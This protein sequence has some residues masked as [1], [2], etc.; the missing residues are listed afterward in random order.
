[1]SAAAV[2]HA[3]QQWEAAHRRL[4]EEASDPARRERLYSGV[5]RINAEL[6]RR[7]GATFTLAELAEVYG[8]SEAWVWE[9]LA[10][11]PQ[12]P[13]WPRDL[14]LI[15]DAAFHLYARGAADYRP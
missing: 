12:T 10:E 14:A 6:R 15:S 8:D 11:E 1:V 13:G 5:E 9:A 4:G 2:E 3:R 7:V